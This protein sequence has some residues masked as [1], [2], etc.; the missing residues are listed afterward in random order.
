MNVV[1]LKAFGD[2]LEKIA[3]LR[4]AGKALM[5]AAHMGWHGV[6]GTPSAQHWF[7][8]GLA[9]AAER[10]TMGRFGKAFDTATSLGG[11]TKYLPVG[12][13]SLM[14]AGALGQAQQA[15]K[16]EDPTGQGRSRL[17]RGVGLAGNLAGGLVG[18]GALLRTG[19][20]KKHPILSSMIGGIGG[21]MLGEKLVTA[22]WRDGR[23][24]VGRA[25]QQ[26]Q[27]PQQQY[28]GVPA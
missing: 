6:A 20:G 18:T 10:A 25:Y 22:P 21:G 19:I 3:I 12:A 16:P 13:K 14:V 23:N 26:Q 8:Q 4:R 24:S 5:D 9:P 28:S 11:A 1:S 2:E 15:L 17:E 7:G 27:M